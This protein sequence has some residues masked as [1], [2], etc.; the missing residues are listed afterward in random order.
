M[1]DTLQKGLELSAADKRVLLENLLRQQVA[2]PGTVPLSFAQQR[3]WFLDQLES[4]SAIFNISRAIRMIGHLDVPA[5]EKTFMAL[6]ARH[7]SLRTNFKLIDGEAA[8][9]ILPV[10]EMEISRVDIRGLR[11]EERELEFQRL[12]AEGGRR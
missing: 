8:Q 7:E 5:L 10:R 6:I 9:V 1:K 2:R 4:D 12:G 11:P 3:L